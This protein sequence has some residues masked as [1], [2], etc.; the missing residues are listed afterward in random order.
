MY[1]NGQDVD[2]VRVGVDALEIQKAR[3]RTP[4]PGRYTRDDG[5][6]LPS[7]GQQVEMIGA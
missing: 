3:P 4:Y 2:E 6:P 7:I 1:G 5:I